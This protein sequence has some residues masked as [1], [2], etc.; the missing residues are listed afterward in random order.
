[1]HRLRSLTLLVTCPPEHGRHGSPGCRR[2]SQAR[3]SR[4]P[5]T[6]SPSPG[7]PSYRREARGTSPWQ[8]LSDRPRATP[9][10]TRPST[11]PGTTPTR[12]RACHTAPR[13]SASSRPQDGSCCPS[14]R[15]TTHIRPTSTRH[16]RSS[17]SSCSPPG[18]V[19]HCASV[20]NWN[21]PAP[22]PACALRLPRNCWQSSQ[23]TISTGFFG[24]LKLLGLLCMT[25]SHCSCVTRY[26]PR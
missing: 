2:K 14:S 21:L 24:P 13:H 19:F 10:N 1:M 23:L 20:G 16:P 22:E 18:S 26:L 4:G 25:A 8:H 3:R 7:C 15:N 6:G 17:I 11:N 12:S 5:P 9:C